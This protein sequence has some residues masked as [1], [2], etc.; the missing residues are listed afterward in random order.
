MIGWHP[1]AYHCLDVAVVVEAILLARPVSRARCAS[2]LGMS[3]SDSI[4]LLTAM[5]ALHDIGK[6]SKS[7]FGQTAEL[8]PDIE[9]PCD[10]STPRRAHTEAGYALWRNGLREHVASHLRAGDVHDLEILMAAAF[11]H[12]GRPLSVGGTIDLRPYFS[13]KDTRS[14]NSAIAFAIDAINVFCPDGIPVP[15][16]EQR[17][18]RA[19]WW[20]AGLLST[21]DWIGSSQKWFAYREP[22]DPI[23]DYLHVAR[24]SAARAIAAAGLVAPAS[25]V[26]RD[27]AQLTGATWSPSPI[28]R[29][30]LE[31][32]LPSEPALFII[33]DVTGAGKTEAAQV[34]VHRLMAAGRA[35]GAYW[36][37]PT[38]ATA[39]AMYAR[40][41][42]AIGALFDRQG[43]LS[44]SVVLSHGQARL[45]DDFRSTVLTGC[46]TTGAAREDS[47]AE[48]GSESSIACSAFLADDRR[49]G[50]LADVGAGTIDQALLGVLPSRFNTI[51]LFAL[52]EK[53]LVLDEVHAYDAYVEGEMQSLLEF[54][55]AMGGSVV[56]L[57]AT[58]SQRQRRAFVNAWR[59]G[60]GVSRYSADESRWRAGVEA[61]AVPYPLATIVNGGQGELQASPGIAPWSRRTVPV[62]FVHDEAVVIDRIV[63]ASKTGQAV[64][65]I[66]NTVDGCIEG[67]RQLRAAGLEPLVFHSRFAQCDRQAIEAKVMNAFGP[68][69]E[70]VDRAHVV[71]ATQ[72]IEQSLDLDFDMLVTDLAPIDLVI[73]RA[74]RLWRHAR[75]NRPMGS[76]MQLIVLAPR[77][78][79]EPGRAWLDAVLPKTKNVYD[80]VGVLWRS[81]RVLT[82]RPEIV[83]PEGIRGM[84][85]QVYAGDDV[86]PS[87]EKAVQA[88]TGRSAAKGAMAR[89]FSLDVTT[90]YCKNYAAGWYADIHVPTRLIDE[91]TVLRLAKAGGDG[92][93]RPWAGGQP[94][95]WRAWALSEVRVSSRKLGKGAQ[96][97]AQFRE[98]VERL[99]AEWPK[100]ERDVVVVPMQCFEGWSAQLTSPKGEILHARYGD[101]GLRMMADG[102]PIS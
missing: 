20:V 46:E 12:H 90:G 8:W 43:G 89:N 85:E 40:Q 87:L 95:D 41:A 88:A 83:T 84:V 59:A 14:M 25:A 24:E 26:E 15:P 22:V 72:V 92:E 48:E 62:A 77:H 45:H 64:A 79:E 86:P 21:A 81:L 39:N 101:E 74:G 11:G 66:R 67:A 10:Q 7:F 63:A 58:L 51:R 35:S 49:A 31:V 32:E 56:M 65:W 27:F 70:P 100:Y 76:C 23:G 17:A 68:K 6:F 102:H 97:E 28:Q 55:A 78:S 30:A 99:R 53:V 52:A 47:D 57:S 61:M 38:Q 42:K 94:E 44:P 69:S 2:L 18:L 50:L 75:T 34:L 73:Q 82:E 16:S 98:A 91:Q 1:T 4:V 96:V 36:G 80:D 33:E 19:S 60:C 93:L 37:M 3:E 9:G 71:V 5:A 13:R 29:W 54:Q